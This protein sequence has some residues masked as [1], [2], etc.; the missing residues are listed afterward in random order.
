MEPS[1]G[2]VQATR[3]IKPPWNFPFSFCFV[4]GSFVFLVT[5]GG[6]VRNPPLLTNITAPGSLPEIQTADLGTHTQRYIKHLPNS[7]CTGAS[8]GAAPFAQVSRRVQRTLTSL[9]CKFLAFCLTNC[10]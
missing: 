2:Q 4:L 7:L 8:S 5:A 6:I 9:M 10:N 3:I 1:G